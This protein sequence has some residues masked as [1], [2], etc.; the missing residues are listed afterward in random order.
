M[1]RQKTKPDTALKIRALNGSIGMVAPRWTDVAVVRQTVGRLGISH[2][3]ITCHR[4]DANAGA[5]RLSTVLAPKS[6]VGDHRAIACPRCGT[7]GLCRLAVSPART[8]S[9]ADCSASHHRELG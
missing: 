5:S 1:A 7:S 9:A 8:R 2:L 6:C 3:G 4:S